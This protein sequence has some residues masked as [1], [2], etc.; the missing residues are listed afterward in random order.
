[1]MDS[2]VVGGQRRNILDLIISNSAGEDN[3]EIY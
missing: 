1:M 2:M 3:G